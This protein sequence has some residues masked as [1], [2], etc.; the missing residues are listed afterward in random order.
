MN[1][2]VNI[3]AMNIASRIRQC[4]KALQL[5]KAELADKT[6]LTPAAITQFEEGKRLPSAESLKKLGDVL[7]VSVGYLLG[8]EKDE[9]F[10]KDPQL[11]AI[12]RGMKKLAPEDIK[13]M[14]SVYEHLRS[15]AKK[16]GGTS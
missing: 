1:P 13:F 7:Q 12:F 14:Q 11:Q 16:S 6:G 9:E 8:T 4:R 5:T 15:K 10:L 2:C 3:M